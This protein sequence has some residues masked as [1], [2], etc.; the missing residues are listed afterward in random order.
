MKQLI[1]FVFLSVC[2]TVPSFAGE[3][4]RGRMLPSE[5]LNP[6]TNGTY[7]KPAGCFQKN[8]NPGSLNGQSF[9]HRVPD[10]NRYINTAIQATQQLIA[11][12]KQQQRRNNARKMANGLA[13]ELTDYLMN[14]SNVTGNPNDYNNFI[15]AMNNKNNLSDCLFNDLS[16]NDYSYNKL[17]NA[18]SQRDAFYLYKSAITQCVPFPLNIY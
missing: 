1:L 6:C 2:L 9:Q 4:L 5:N 10:V 3:V 7:P 15:L 12:Q 8:Y 14:R 11:Q 18:S 17:F 16:T 13:K